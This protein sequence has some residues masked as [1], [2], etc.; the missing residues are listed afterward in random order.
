MD[1]PRPNLQ[2][3]AL[4]Y[5]H[6]GDRSD[7]R[8]NAAVRS[9]L[10]DLDDGVRCEAFRALARISDPNNELVDTFRAAIALGVELRTDI[11][12][13][14]LAWGRLEQCP[15]RA[16]AMPGQCKSSARATSARNPE[17]QAVP[18]CLQ[19]MRKARIIAGQGQT[20][21]IS[22]FLSR[23]SVQRGGPE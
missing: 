7:G 11:F 3:C 6:S 8:I 20:L 13:L 19:A 21:S 1:N 4:G 9:K 14:C 16:H 22:Q 10:L 17:L 2:C 15:G 5:L 23:I 12:S 18:D